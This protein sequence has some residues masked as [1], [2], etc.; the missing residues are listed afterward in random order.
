MSEVIFTILMMGDIH[1]SY[2]NE[3]KFSVCDLPFR[4][5]LSLKLIEEK[6]KIIDF[7]DDIDILNTRANA[8]RKSDKSRKEA[9]KSLT[10]AYKNRGYKFK[11]KHDLEYAIRISNYK[12]LSNRKYW[13]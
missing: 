2:S 12:N 3:L 6:S 7:S 11:I 5:E 13:I 9:L 1:F 4:T 10:N 8:L